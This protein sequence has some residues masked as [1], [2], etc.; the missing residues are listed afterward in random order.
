M[1]FEEIQRVEVDEVRLEPDILQEASK[2][3]MF[4]AILS[5]KMASRSEAKQLESF[6]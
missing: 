6:E 4:S 3:G 1:I 2:A 5:R